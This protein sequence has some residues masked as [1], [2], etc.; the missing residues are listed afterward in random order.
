MVL[1]SRESLAI[2]IAAA[3]MLGQTSFGSGE[4]QY[5]PITET[6]TVQATAVVRHR[7][8][9]DFEHSKVSILNGSGFAAANAGVQSVR[10]PCTFNMASMA[11]LGTAYV[12][13]TDPSQLGIAG[14]SSA[15][16]DVRVTGSVGEFV[17][18]LFIWAGYAACVRPS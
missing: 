11:T 1:L 12:L 6:G 3:G 5:G 4:F 14:V 7:D 16:H 13:T 17:G 18:L 8:D 9:T 2:A 10:N 15:F